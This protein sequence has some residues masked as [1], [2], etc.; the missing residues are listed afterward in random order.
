[1]QI[2]M[3]S[4]SKGFVNVSKEELKEILSSLE[5]SGNLRAENLSLQDYINITKKY[6]EMIK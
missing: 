3:N 4:L 1:M 5:L 6:T 2:I